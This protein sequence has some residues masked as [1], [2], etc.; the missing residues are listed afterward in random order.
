VSD[1]VDV[2]SG[3]DESV[4]YGRRA[5]G[6]GVV[7][8]RAYYAPVYVDTAMTQQHL[9]D[10]VTAQAARQRQRRAALAVGQVDVTACSDSITAVTSSRAP[11]AVRAVMPRRGGE[12]HAKSTE[13]T[14]WVTLSF[15]QTKVDNGE[16]C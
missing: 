13:E 16:L 11:A 3:G 5:D 12:K 4:D 15:A 14:H 2:T 10:D 8:R 7:Q 1:L 6:G 9:H